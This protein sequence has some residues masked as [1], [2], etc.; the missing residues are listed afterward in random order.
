MT[1]DSDNVKYVVNNLQIT[2]DS[3]ARE[4]IKEYDNGIRKAFNEYYKSIGYNSLENRV[5]NFQAS[6][7]KNLYDRDSEFISFKN[8]YDRTNNL[9]EPERKLLKYV[10]YKLN[11]IYNNGNSKFSS[12]ED[13]KIP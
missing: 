10:L 4:F 1:V 2:H 3:I 7:F 13:P 12:E 9:T 6:T 5:I 11:W 8:P